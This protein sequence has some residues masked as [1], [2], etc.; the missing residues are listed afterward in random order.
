MNC[1]KCGAVADDGAEE[2]AGCGIVFSRWRDRP[3]R[4]SLTNTPLPAPEQRVPA[5]LIIAGVIVFVVIGIVWTAHRRA[6]RASQKDDLTAQLDEINNKG[7][8][9]R[10]RIR[11]EATKGYQAAEHDRAVAAEAAAKAARQ[12]PPTITEA[13]LR[14]LIEQDAFFQESVVAPVPKVFDGREYAS[15]ARRYPALINAV[16]E[17]LVEFDPPFDPKAPRTTDAQIQVHVPSAALYKVAGINDRGDTY[18]IDL[19]RRRLDTLTIESAGDFKIE[20]GLTF[21][22]EH[23]VGK[24]L[25]PDVKARG[26]ASLTRGANGWRVDSLTHE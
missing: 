3:L 18:E 22:Y 14:T 23:P 5:S 16:R 1:P 12:L 8:A 11:N 9:E 15:V 20:T 21:T 26:H 19:G 25:L 10:D 24:A 13:D 4:P 2:C 6:A 7:Q 17:E